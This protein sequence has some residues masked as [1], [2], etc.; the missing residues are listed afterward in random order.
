MHFRYLRLDVQ[1]LSIAVLSYQTP[2]QFVELRMDI[3]MLLIFA[4]PGM[5]QCLPIL[6]IARL[7]LASLSGE[8]LE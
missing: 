3:F 4:T 7:V 5:K 2:L 1:M 8:T 6:L